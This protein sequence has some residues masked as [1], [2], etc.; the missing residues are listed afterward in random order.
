MFKRPL[1]STFF[2]FW[3][4]TIHSFQR[5]TI[6]SLLEV[7]FELIVLNMAEYYKPPTLGK[8]TPLTMDGLR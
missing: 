7:V 6:P 5:E 4:L 2:F 1:S 3:K 8:A